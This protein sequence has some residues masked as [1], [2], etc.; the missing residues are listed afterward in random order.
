MKL[1]FPNIRINHVFR[2]N[3]F[4]S[5]R[6]IKIPEQAPDD[7]VRK[8]VMKNPKMFFTELCGTFSK[9]DLNL[10]EFYRQFYLKSGKD[11]DKEKKSLT[12]FLTGEMNSFFINVS[13]QEG[14][15]IPEK[16]TQSF[17]DK[18]K[19]V[20]LRLFAIRKIQ[21]GNPFHL[22]TVPL[23]DLFDTDLGMQ[24]PTYSR[25]I[26]NHPADRALWLVGS[27][28]E[29]DYTEI[30]KK[31]L[32][33]S[34]LSD[35]NLGKKKDKI[36][37]KLTKLLKSDKSDFAGGFSNKELKE[38]KSYLIE[39]EGINRIQT[40]RGI[41]TKNEE[42]IRYAS[43]VPENAKQGDYINGL[44]Y[45][46]NRFSLNVKGGESI[47]ALTIFSNELGSNAFKIYS[48]GK[49]LELKNRTDVNVLNEEKDAL[50]AEVRFVYS[51]KDNTYYI[52][53]L[54]NHNPQKY[55]NAGMIV[56]LELLRLLASKNCLPL[57]FKA[58]AYA[59]SNKSPVNYYRRFGFSPVTYTEKE[60]EDILNSN[61]GV[62]PVDIPV[63]FCLKDFES[64]R[65][66][67]KIYEKRF[68]NQ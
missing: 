39:Y 20:T 24:N 43:L 32:K 46:V 28:V 58:E 54:L 16:V 33:Y 37:R 44:G 53:N 40:G 6:G 64:L 42:R 21:A 41:Y 57:S 34:K 30:A 48:L 9:E 52:S 29:E 7:F 62:F 45:V 61:N 51:N 18:S 47:Q 38:I 11:L 25:S 50:L 1:H 17:K 66:R 3:F 35:K 19:E 36:L 49:L 13:P 2:M 63:W 5:L 65:K 14:I 26:F 67:I 27:F 55:P 10:V 59:G 22:K 56:G 15:L 31:A 23:S 68:F 4:N 8:C 60:L 12:D